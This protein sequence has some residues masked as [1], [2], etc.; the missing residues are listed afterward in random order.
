MW[1]NIPLAGWLDYQ[2]FLSSSVLLYHCLCSSSHNGF[3]GFSL[4]TLPS[5]FLF[6][7][8]ISGVFSL[9]IYRVLYDSSIDKWCPIIFCFPC[10]IKWCHSI[11]NQIYIEWKRKNKTRIFCTDPKFSLSSSNK[12]TSYTFSKLSPLVQGGIAKL[13]SLQLIPEDLSALKRL[14]S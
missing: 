7:H 11:S 3:F 5:S 10:P 6:D 14:W 2:I 1:P 13:L 8:L 4:E 9:Q 12:I